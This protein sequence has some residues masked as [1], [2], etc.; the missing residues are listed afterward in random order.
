MSETSNARAA[1][2][3]STP[4]SASS[5]S[6]STAGASTAGA[7]IEFKNITKKYRGQSSPAVDNLSLEIPA[8]E[9]VAFVGPSGCG[10]TTS[11]KMINRL[12]EP[13]SG[14]ILINGDDAIKRNPTE[15]RRQI[16]YVI[17]GGGLFPIFQSLTISL[18]CLRF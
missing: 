7:S 2:D 3:S 12:V 14:Q 5:T 6:T 9:L 1:S 15:L 10:K 13:T 11:L 17:Q 16:G 4:A 18:W 8:G